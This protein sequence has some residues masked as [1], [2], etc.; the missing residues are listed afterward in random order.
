MPMAEYFSSLDKKNR[1]EKSFII[2]NTIH[3]REEFLMKMVDMHL[4]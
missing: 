1:K 4:Q 2:F 3:L